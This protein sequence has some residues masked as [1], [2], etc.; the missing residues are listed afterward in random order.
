MSRHK[1]R[2]RTVQVEV[3]RPEIREGGIIS[4]FAEN[5]SLDLKSTNDLMNWII[6]GEEKKFHTLPSSSMTF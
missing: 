2:N 4:T 1:N 5:M 6:F 3:A